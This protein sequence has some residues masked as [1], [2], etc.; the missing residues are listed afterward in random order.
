MFAEHGPAG[1]G[2]QGLVGPARAV[3]QQQSPGALAEAL[4][5]QFEPGGRLRGDGGNAARDVAGIVPGFD[6]QATGRLPDGVAP[7]DERQH[8]LAR[9]DQSRVPAGTEKCLD[10]GERGS[11]VE[12]HSGNRHYDE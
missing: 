8:F 7:L 10:G 1:A 2:L 5:V 6:S 3:D 11:G 9:L 4:D 12:V